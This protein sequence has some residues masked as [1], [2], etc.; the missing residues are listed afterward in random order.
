[1]RLSDEQQRPTA[2]S[3]DSKRV[4]VV[5]RGAR[6]AYQVS[7]ALA[8]AGLLE[9]LVTDLYWPEDRSWARA[10]TKLLPASLRFSL[11]AR[12][13]AGLPS[14]KVRLSIPYGPASFA[15]DKLPRVPFVW[16]QRAQ[17]STDAALGR[18]AAQISKRSGARLLSYSYY[19]YDAFAAY[20]GAHTLFQLHPHPA[21]IRRILRQELT[22]HPDCAVSLNKEW[23]LS[24]PEPDYERLTAEPQLAAHILCAS[25]FTRKTMIENGT[26]A[27][28]IEV[29]PYGVD[30]ERFRPAPRELGQ[31]G[32]GP[33]RLLFVGTINQRKGIK[34]L[35]EAIRLLAHPRIELTVC[36]RVVDDLGLF[37]GHTSSVQVR[38]S[39]S[40]P[41]LIRAYQ[42]ADLFV[43]PSVAEGFG[44][45]LLEAL[46]SGLPI[47]ST[48]HTAA[49]DLI[50]DGIQGFVVPPRRP[51]LLAERIEWALLHRRQLDHMKQAARERAEQFTWARFRDGIIAGL[52]RFEGSETQRETEYFEYV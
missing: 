15:L 24:L 8:E 33:L 27:A 6:D 7:R 44:Q 38:P 3:K 14:S 2:K 18:K 4:V 36:G 16:R 5:H 41:E 52:R 37:A 40:L 34:Y 28:S 26:P 20:P 35:L 43:F 12:Y 30:L 46:A 13:A 50:E 51:D 10:L 45:V 47:L 42:R 19:A 25:S 21:S 31:S 22:D 39:V 17:R 9:S 11:R 1:M 29:V 23:E 32:S 48:T 49:P